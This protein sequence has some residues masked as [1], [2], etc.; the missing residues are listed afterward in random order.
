MK[1]QSVSV[2]PRL[3]PHRT[4]PL[5][6]LTTA[7]PASFDASI[8]MKVLVQ[9]WCSGPIGVMGKRSGRFKAS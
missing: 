9:L 2:E 4:S 8:V 3:R 5:T 6:R 7:F 1:Y